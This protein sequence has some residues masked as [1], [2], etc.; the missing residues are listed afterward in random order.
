MIKPIDYQ[1]NGQPVFLTFEDLKEKM[2][3]KTYKPKIGNFGRALIKASKENNQGRLTWLNKQLDEL[4]RKQ[5]QE[6]K[7]A[8]EKHNDS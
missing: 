3:Y 1:S 4:F 8:K 7:K 6:Y 2:G 5:R